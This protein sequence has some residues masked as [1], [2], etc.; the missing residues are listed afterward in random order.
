[1]NLLESLAQTNLFLIRR[2]ESADAY[3]PLASLSPGE[4]RAAAREVAKAS[5]WE[6]VSPETRAR[7][8]AAEAARAEAQAN[9]KPFLVE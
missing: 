7:I 9:P 8:E 1:M 5:H 3:E 2:M 4:Y 6:D